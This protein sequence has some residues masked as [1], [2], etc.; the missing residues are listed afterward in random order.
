MHCIN[1]HR[2]WLSMGTFYELGRWQ[3]RYQALNDFSFYCCG[4][5]VVC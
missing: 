2:C 3:L 4:L 5:G 1:M